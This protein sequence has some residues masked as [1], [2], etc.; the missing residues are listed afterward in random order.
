MQRDYIRL[1]RVFSQDG[2]DMSGK[3]VLWNFFRRSSQTVNDVYEA[4]SERDSGLISGS[5]DRG[6][7][8]RLVGRRQQWKGRA[9][10]RT[11]CRHLQAETQKEV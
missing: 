5:E 1:S 4:S 9:K 6:R 3:G 2:L 11:R 8:G 10:S 7:R